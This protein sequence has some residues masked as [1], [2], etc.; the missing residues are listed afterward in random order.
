MYAV[1]K[2]GGKQYRV[3]PGQTVRVEKIE[4]G[5]GDTVSLKDVLLIGQDG[6]VKTGADLDGAE[7]T[8]TIVEQH[9]A[10]KILVF[11]KKR[12]QGYRR[13]KGHRQR[14]TA[15]RVNEIKPES[16]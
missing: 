14:Y 11:K 5:V 8:A 9:R 10:K 13:T 7:V 1:I 15:L 3:T 16:A 4:G 12:R 6:D 2:T